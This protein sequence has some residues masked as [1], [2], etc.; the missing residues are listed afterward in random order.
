MRAQ[1]PQFVWEGVVDG[2]SVLSIRG[3]RVQIEDR[4]GLPVQRQRYRFFERLPDSRV[5]VRLEV[6]EG[7]RLRPHHPATAAWIT[8][9]TLMVSIEDRQD[10]SSFYSLEFYWDSSRGGFFGGLLGTRT[11]RQRQAGLERP[12]GR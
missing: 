6:R 5:E 2:T 10:G 9:F 8:N 3:N 11:Q 4:E 12:R 1:S 7:A